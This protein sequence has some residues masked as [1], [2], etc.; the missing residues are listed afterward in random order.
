MRPIKPI[1]IDRVRTISAE[2]SLAHGAPIHAGDPAAIDFADIDAPDYGEA[3]P[4]EDDEIPVFLACGV[5]P[6]NAALSTN[7]PLFI[8]HRPGAMLITDVDERANP[9]VLDTVS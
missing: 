6:Q 4:V 8:S 9:P 2:F 1:D 3:V 5:T 7:L